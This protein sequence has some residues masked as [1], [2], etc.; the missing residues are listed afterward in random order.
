MALKATEARIAGANAQLSQAQA[1]R[2]ALDPQIE[3][4]KVRFSVPTR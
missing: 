3:N 1:N 4:A 2:D